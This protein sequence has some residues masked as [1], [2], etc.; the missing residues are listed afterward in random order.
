VLAWVT[1]A[2]TFALMGITAF[3]A[4]SNYRVM[5]IMET[6]IRARTQP[7]PKLGVDLNSSTQPRLHK[8]TNMTVVIRT[9]NAPMRLKKLSIH[10]TY[11]DGQMSHI[12]CMIGDPRIISPLTAAEFSADYESLGAVDEWTA[13][14]AYTDLGESTEYVMKLNSK[15]FSLTT[16]EKAPGAFQK[17]LA[18]A[19]EQIYEM[20]Q[21]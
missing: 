13:L 19:K 3:Y 11:I 4:W 2:L 10:P 6:D 9:E 12:D 18:K 7:I 16:M 17:L 14:I 20:D 1:A 15:G 21:E 5:R 8:D